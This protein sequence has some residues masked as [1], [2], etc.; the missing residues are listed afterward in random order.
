MHGKD[1][2]ARLTAGIVAGSR[3]WMSPTWNASPKWA[4]YISRLLAV[5]IVGECDA[6]S[7]ALEGVAHQADASE[8]LGDGTLREK[9]DRASRLI[10]SKARRRHWSGSR[11]TSV[12][13][14]RA[15]FQPR[16]SSAA[17][18]AMSRAMFRRIL[19]SQ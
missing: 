11:L 6:P 13:Q 18:F 4:V 14:N 15:T 19:R 8:E 12:S 17:V 16:S 9:A 1:A 5:D 2:V 3:W 10:R 7:L